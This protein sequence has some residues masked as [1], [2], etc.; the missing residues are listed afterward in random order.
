MPKTFVEVG[1][2]ELVDA[3]KLDMSIFSRNAAFIAFDL[4]ELFYHE[5]PSYRDMLSNLLKEVLQMCRVGEIKPSPIATFDVSEIGQA[6]RCFS[7]KDRIGKVVVSFGDQSYLS[8]RRN[9]W[10]YSAPAGFTY[11]G[12]L[13]SPSRALEEHDH[14]EGLDFSLL[15]SSVSRSVGTATESNYC[16]ANAFLDAFAHW[17]RTQGKPAVSIEALLLRRGIQPLS[18]DEF[19]EVIEIRG[20]DPE[21]SH[22]LTGLEPFRIRE[23]RAKGFDV[24]HGTMQD[25]RASLI[26]FAFQ[27]HSRSSDGDTTDSPEVSQLPVAHWLRGLP[28]SVASAMAAEVNA[29]SLTDAV[30]RVATKQFSNLMLVKPDQIDSGKPLL[31]YGVDSM[32]A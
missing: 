2:R 10:Q 23:L 28:A 19:L 25:S 17:R 7:L 21:S 18:E 12:R 13:E 14:D 29:T 6:Y 4:D 8:L 11:F 5:H 32:I 24:S 31:D 3:G 22:I 1:K 27:G 15:T 26:A 9:T 30:L 20:R 16:A